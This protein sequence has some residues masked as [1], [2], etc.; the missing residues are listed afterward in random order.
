MWAAI[1]VGVASFV[2]G[3]AFV[4]V[5]RRKRDRRMDLESEVEKLNTVLARAERYKPENA[6]TA[7]KF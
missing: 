2:V 6:R 4:A 5:A 7:I 1:I 3:M